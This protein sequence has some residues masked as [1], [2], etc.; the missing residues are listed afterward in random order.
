MGTIWA[1]VVDESGTGADSSDWL[2]ARLNDTRSRR[3][4]PFAVEVFCGAPRHSHSA[5]TDL[6]QDNPYMTDSNAQFRVS[7]LSLGEMARNLG[8]LALVAKRVIPDLRE[9]TPSEHHN[10]QHYY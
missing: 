5:E 6:L 8:H 7:P 4:R 10:L 9:M 2:Y 3:D 1:P